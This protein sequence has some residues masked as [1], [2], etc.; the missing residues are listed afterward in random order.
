MDIARCWFFD[1]KIEFIADDYSLKRASKIGFNAMYCMVDD[2]LNAKKE[3]I[4]NDINA[5]YVEKSKRDI[6]IIEEYQKQFPIVRYRVLYNGHIEKLVSRSKAGNDF[7][8]SLTGLM[9]CNSFE[10]W[11]IK[12]DN[13]ES[14]IFQTLSEKN[15]TELFTD[16]EEAK[17]VSKEMWDK[18]VAPNAMYRVAHY[19]DDMFE[20]Y[21]TDVLNKKNAYN[22]AVKLNEKRKYLHYYAIKIVDTEK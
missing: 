4:E 10:E 8:F 13:R 22:A 14:N 1:T 11:K 3:Y 16:F 21:V 9:D 19:F 2:L 17:K 18:E 5:E 6:A 15:I 12:E 20:G 7:V